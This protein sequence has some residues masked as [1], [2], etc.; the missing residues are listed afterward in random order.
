MKPTHM[1]S[2]TRNLL[3]LDLTFG[4]S[5][6]VKRWLTGFGELSFQWIQICIVSP[7]RRSSFPLLLWLGEADNIVSYIYL[8]FIMY[9]TFIHH[10][11][12]GP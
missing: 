6:K 2:W 10:H 5:L 8:Y 11:L 4:P 12:F 7:M 3:M 9:V 1:K